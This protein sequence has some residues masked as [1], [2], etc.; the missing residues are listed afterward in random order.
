MDC[1][2]LRH[3][4]TT[5][6]RCHPRVPTFE[7]CPKIPWMGMLADG[8][9]TGNRNP[10]AQTVAREPATKTRANGQEVYSCTYLMQTS[11]PISCQA[12]IGMLIPSLADIS[13]GRVS[14]CQ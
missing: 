8:L 14:A 11:K 6:L 7:P 10:R 2:A 1:I 12:I 13:S 9:R 5:S 3:T 4:H